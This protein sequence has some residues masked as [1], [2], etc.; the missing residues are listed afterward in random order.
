MEIEQ[1]SVGPDSVL[2]VLL[3]SEQIGLVDNE[4]CAAIAEHVFGL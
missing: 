4:Y 1:G 3:L 2:V